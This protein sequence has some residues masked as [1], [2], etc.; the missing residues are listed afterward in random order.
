MCSLLR[1][2]RG[3]ACPSPVCCKAPSCINMS[4]YPCAPVPFWLS[5]LLLCRKHVWPFMRSRVSAPSILSCAQ[6]ACVALHILRPP[7]GR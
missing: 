6:E 2:W 7:P 5:L 1:T 4:G 3:L